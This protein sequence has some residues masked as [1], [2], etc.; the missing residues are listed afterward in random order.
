MRYWIAVTAVSIFCFAAAA[1][2]DFIY[3]IVTTAG[4][5][6]SLDEIAPSG[7]VSTIVSGLDSP[8]G[9]AYNALQNCFDVA[10]IEP[11]TSPE[12]A[13]IEQIT[14]SGGVS[15]FVS[16]LPGPISALAY[17]NRDNLYAAFSQSGI[18]DKISPA[19]GVS[20]Y[21]SGLGTVLALA[22]DSHVN[23]FA[24]TDSGNSIYEI[25]PSGSPSLFFQNL[26]GDPRSL[27]INDNNEL[28]VSSGDD[29]FA[30]SPTGQRSLYASNSSGEGS[31]Y[32]ASNG[33]LFAAQGDVIGVTTSPQGAINVTAP[34]TLGA[35]SDPSTSLP[36]PEPAGLGIF[37]LAAM[38]FRRRPS[39]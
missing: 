9:L 25:P 20:Q 36:V 33:Q 28:Y 12:L 35:I 1:R 39:S 29:I 27:A 31:L 16:G 13:A 11:G 8:T 22:F 3:A 18:V 5:T 10:V 19:D 7:N 26:C 17:D 32:I 14:P 4:P 24:A 37:A 23:L 30:I 38:L 21:A 6:Y 2:A 34:G 15:T